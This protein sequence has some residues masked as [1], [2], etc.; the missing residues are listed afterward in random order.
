MGKLFK[1]IE[2]QIKKNL[3]NILILLFK[4]GHQLKERKLQARFFKIL[5]NICFYI[6]GNGLENAIQKCQNLNLEINIGIKLK[7]KSWI[8]GLKL[9]TNMLFELQSHSKIHLQ[10]YIKITN[11]SSLFVNNLIYSKTRTYRCILIP[12]T[13]MQLIKKQK[14][15][16][17]N[18]G[19]FF[20]STDVIENENI[21]PYNLKE[22]KKY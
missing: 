14:G 2:V 15:H 20:K 10:R 18:C 3:F 21:I 9:S 22:Q 16:C 4:N 11:K 7:K 6:F 17:I 19:R 5:I 1:N 8:F 12:S 13:K